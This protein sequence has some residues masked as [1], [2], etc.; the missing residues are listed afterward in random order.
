MNIIVGN[1]KMPIKYKEIQSFTQT[2]VESF[3]CNCCGE[4]FDD[5]ISIQ[6][7]LYWAATGGYGSVWGDG[8]TVELVLCQGCAAKHLDKYMT[9]I[10]NES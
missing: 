9:E 3:T 6:E 5:V 1:V 2:V 7:M 10:Y 4:T 8:N